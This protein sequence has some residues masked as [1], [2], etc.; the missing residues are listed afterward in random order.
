MIHNKNIDDITFNDIKYLID[1]NFEENKF[2]EYKSELQGK[3]EKKQILKS[4]CGF[5]NSEG[6]LFIYGISED[7]NNLKPKGVSIP[8]GWDKKRLQLVNIIK[9]G[10]EP[11]NINYKI[12]KVDIENSDKVIIL[13]EVK[14]SFNMPHRVVNAH[15]KDFYIRKDGQTESM[16]YNNLKEY[17]SLSEKLLTKINE[18]RENRIFNFYSARENNIYKTIYHAIPLSA[19]SSED[20]D[21]NSLRNILIKNHDLFNGSYFPNF[22]GIYKES[23]D[24]FLQFYRNGIIELVY[25]KKGD[26]ILLDKKNFRKFIKESFE[27]Y[28]ELDIK[29]QV[30]FYITLVN[31]KGKNFDLDNVFV[32]KYNIYDKE[33]E[34]LPSNSLL[35]NQYDEN[36]VERSL[37]NIFLIFKNHFGYVE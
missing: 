4:V 22:E 25:F 36:L 8:N 16:E 30:V 17:F 29:S 24:K 12:N 18:F 23:N 31:I 28:Y 14:K 3:N 9:N 26:N 37:E 7:K 27:L 2:L 19:F 13:I 6:G 34:I 5:A 35:L 32:E 21:M 1:S 33:R 10:I 15:I 20:L 11:N